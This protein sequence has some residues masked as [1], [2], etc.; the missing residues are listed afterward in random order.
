MG[1][2]TTSAFV[3]RGILLTIPRE[4]LSIAQMPKQIE[5]FSSGGVRGYVR[6]EVLLF[7]GYI[8]LKSH[9]GGV[10]LSGA[11][12]TGFGGK[13]DVQTEHYTHLYHFQSST[14]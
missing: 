13:S 10:E 1:G 14:I 6:R 3:R 4:I 9:S 8:G 7:T 5:S 2:L 11:S 12:A